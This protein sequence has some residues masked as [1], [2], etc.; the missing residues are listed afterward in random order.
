VNQLGLKNQL[1]VIRNEYTQGE[2]FWEVFSHSQNTKAVNQ[3]SHI[4][5][6]SRQM[7]LS[8]C[9]GHLC[10]SGLKG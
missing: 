1:W 9:N 10:G 2:I 6:S 7:N 5:I 3:R 8:A 4:G